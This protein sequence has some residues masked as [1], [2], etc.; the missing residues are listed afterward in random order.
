[1]LRDY[2]YDQKVTHIE[3]VL[4]RFNVDYDPKST[5]LEVLDFEVVSPDSF[6][7]KLRLDTKEYYLYAED[8]IPGLNYIK[9][10]FNN[11]LNV[12][13]WNFVVSKKTLSFEASSPVVHAEVYKEPEDSKQ[14]MHY[15]VDSGHD[16]VFLVETIKD[17]IVF[18]RKNKWFGEV[19]KRGDTLLFK[20]A[21][22]AN[23]N[24]EPR[25]F[26][27]P[28]SQPQVTALKADLSRH[29]LLLSV[30]L[31]LCDAAG[32]KDQPD[33]EAA[34]HL[35]A[36][37]LLGADQEIETVFNNAVWYPEVLIAYGA[38]ISK[39]ESGEIFAA[40]QTVNEQ[41]DWPRA[42]EYNAN[43]DRLRRGIELSPLD[44]AVLKYAGLYIYSSA[45]PSRRPGEV[46]PE[47]LPEVLAII[48][49]A[50]KA[51]EG[52]ELPS[53]ASR[54]YN[55]V[56]KEEWMH[57]QNTVQEA[58][59]NAFPALNK[60]AVRAIGVLICSEAAKRARK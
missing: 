46:E 60:D 37:L 51:S 2:Q 35:F 42:Q 19:I 8:Y 23:E 15:A 22:G 39:L 28:I 48:S 54:E 50:E 56:Q 38:D 14:L 24:H 21:A 5:S 30:L 7:W 27:F 49:I 12:A 41:A 36:T 33:Q 58:V 18:N 4:A 16:F 40:V 44:A 13:S 10:V 55:P 43:Q 29:I 53:W 25:I 31:P 45:L 1:M 17:E 26:F 47:L 9:E 3:A 34:S 52:I 59:K 57:L 20:I 6:M 11:Y 32:L